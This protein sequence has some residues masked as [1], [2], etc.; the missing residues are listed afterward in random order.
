MSLA[1]PMED[2]IAIMCQLHPFPLDHVPPF[3]FYYELEHI[4]VVD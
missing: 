4:F 3:I 1:I 2:T